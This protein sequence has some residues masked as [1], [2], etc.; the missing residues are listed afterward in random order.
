MAKSNWLDRTINFFSPSSGFER[1][2]ARAATEIVEEHSR[3]YEAA[4]WNRRTRNWRAEST[5]ADA[6]AVWDLETLRDRARSMI[7][8]DGYAAAAVEIIRTNVVGE[9]IE[10]KLNHKSKLDIA[11]AL[12]KEWAESPFCD[13]SGNLNFAA[14]Q[15]LAIGAMYADGECFVKRVPLYA[16][17]AGKKVPLKVQLLEADYLN[18]NKFGIN[19]DNQNKIVNGIEYTDRGQRAAYWMYDSHPGDTYVG[20]HAPKT[21]RIPAEDIIHLFDPW[22]IGQQ[23]GVTA[24]APILLKMRDSSELQ[25]A[26]LMRQKIAACFSV[27]ITKQDNL[28]DA[29]TGVS[30]KVEDDGTLSEKVQ[31]ASIQYARPGESVSTVNPPNIDGYDQFDKSTLRR[32]ASGLRIPFSEFTGDLTGL[33]FSAAR[34]ERLGFWRTVGH[35]RWHVLIPKFNDGI[36]K[37]WVQAAGIVDSD[38]TSLTWDWSEPRRERIDPNG[39]IMAELRAVRAGFT[40]RQAVIRSAGYDPEKIN[41]EIKQDNEHADA[42]DFVFDSDARLTSQVGFAQG[43]DQLEMLAGKQKPTPP[44]QGENK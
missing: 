44:K 39:E 35:L 37:W 19:P 29:D 7:R 14:L 31:P 40:S 41:E 30:R 8:D 5:S 25:D 1:L 12:W 26:Q 4:G 13:Y 6:A 38:L 17:E 9:G 42:N 33:S 3:K 23:R 22:R 34:I 27:V 28:G 18:N 43:A 11:K 21:I 2:R 20:G 15:F 36:M 10:I 24:F 16:V 32:I